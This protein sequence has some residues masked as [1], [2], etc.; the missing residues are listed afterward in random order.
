MKIQERPFSVLLALCFIAP[1]HLSSAEAEDRDLWRPTVSIV[2]ERPDGLRLLYEAK[3]GHADDSGFEGGEPIELNPDEIR[4]LICACAIGIPLDA[5]VTVDVVEA[6]VLGWSD[7]EFDNSVGSLRTD[8]PVVLD[9]V[10]LARDQ[11]VARLAFGPS[12]KDG[13]LLA[14]GR[15][16]VD[17]NFDTGLTV[18]TPGSRQDRWGEMMYRSG[19]L[20]YEQARGWRQPPRR[21]ASKLSQ[22][23]LES[24]QA[25]K[26]SVTGK[27]GMVRV[28]GQDLID[29][30]V[31]LGDVDPARMRLL[32]G[33]GL[34]LGRARTVS[35]G[36]DPRES[37]LVVE[38]G[39]DGSFDREDY[40]LF[41]G[42]SPDR[43]DQTGTG[44]YVWRHNLYTEENVYFLELGGRADGRRAGVVS[45]DLSDPEPMV[46]EQYIER[47]HVEDELFILRQFHQIPTG[48]DWYMEDFRGNARNF[49]TVIRD[50]VATEPV[51]VR[52]SF[53]GSSDEVH[54]FEIRWNGT[55]VEDIRYSGSGKSTVEI[56][57]AEGPVE[58]LNQVGLF[59][60]DTFSTRLDWYELEYA[61]KLSAESGE[62]IFD[63]LG[64]SRLSPSASA[65]GVAEFRLSGFDERPRIFDTSEIFEL[66]EV[67]D[68]VYDETE[69]TVAFQ[70]S[71]D[72]S[73]RHPRYFVSAASRWRR[74]AR[75][76][77]ESR[78]S[79]KSPDNGAEYVIITHGDFRNASERLAAWRAEDDRFGLPMSTTVVDVSDIY[80][81]FSAGLLD[82]MAIRSFVNYAVDNWNPSPFFILLVGDGT[83]DYK[84]NSGASHTNWMPAF[85]EGDHTY[86]EWYVR[87]EGDD[88]IPDLA[89]GRLPVRSGTQAED[90][91]DKLINYDR[92]PEVGPWQARALVVSDDVNNPQKPEQ[93]ESFFIY[94]SE[95]LSRNYMPA[96]LNLD[97][98]YIGQ[99]PIEGRTKPQAR[100]AFIEEFNKGALI[101][102]YVGHGNP[103]TLAHEQMFVLSRDISLIDNGRRQ[104]FMYTA[105]SQVGVF[106]DPSRQSMPE[107]LLNLP[108]AGVI[109]FISA[110]RVGYHGSNMLLAFEFHRRMYRS[111]ETHVP[112]GLALTVAK[113]VVDVGESPDERGNVQRYSLMGDPA[114]RLARPRLTVE[115]DGPGEV[116]ALE[117][118]H[119]S[120]R[121]LNSA[122][123]LDT[124]RSGN[125]WLQAFD[126]TARSILEGQ[127]FLQIGA[128]VFRG[129]VAVENGRFELSY[130]IPKDI[131]Y[132]EE[133]LGRVSAYVWSDG[134]PAAYGSLEGILV[135]GTDL[136]VE[137]DED[138]PMITVGFRGQSQFSSGDFVSSRPA[139]ETVIDDPGGINI[140]GEVGHEIE[141]TVDD[142][143]FTATEFFSSRNGSYQ[144]GVLEYELPQLEPGTHE[145]SLKAWDSFNNSSSAQV[146]VEVAERNVTP[147]GDLLFYPNP[148]AESGH[149]TY[150]LAVEAESVRISIFTLAGRFVDKLEVVGEP[151]YNQIAW[152]PS[153][154]L[155]NGSYLY[156]VEVELDS[157]E[158]FELTDALQVVQ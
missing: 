74:P 158:R 97:K 133:A 21:P 101:L 93:L 61:R 83:Y 139:L 124:G 134:E 102:T 14:Y 107:V 41:F 4:S 135:A 15:V 43:W 33:S 137:P 96:D 52:L 136:Q 46:T 34:T 131:A 47:L 60:Q 94:D 128:P 63:W 9:G 72:G 31:N 8:G 100:D 6:R 1:L 23:A 150:T 16:V 80:D 95:T 36:I 112:V 64:A 17:V 51:H 154:S 5:K 122:G 79:L 45:G 29:A 143:T 27:P 22:D 89:I 20:N 57:A 109:G 90:L 116:K 55:P 73:G 129:L 65:S 88:R 78:S 148:M 145:L 35:P 146:V 126:S 98:L 118:V 3:R 106:D 19:V 38:D 70:A 56:E 18:S 50:A 92:S 76:E 141:V 2:E 151:G 114:M 54:R 49:S 155:A 149:F 62:L 39:G 58:G 81:E 59:H 120:G 28:S 42:V 30:G 84:N 140:T 104:P 123:T 25:V 99:F 132:S 10:G 105:A 152:V 69:G 147:L 67:T 119:V 37:A 85:Q 86:D 82:P 108:D 103:E 113:M 121:V 40:V 71:F 13:Q 142:E 11:R 12:R 153:T 44:E 66:T 77:L 125:V 26:I 144:S 130:R 75:I 127:I 111:G 110:T 32:Y 156:H 48:Y 24:H 87:V 157:G 68:F 7:G 115:L 138:G 91:V 53:W 117:E